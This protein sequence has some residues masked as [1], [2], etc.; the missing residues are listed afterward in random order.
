MIPFLQFNHRTVGQVASDI[1]LLL[2]DHVTI[3]LDYFPDVPCHI[4]EVQ[5]FMCMI[6]ANDPSFMSYL[7]L[8]IFPY[9]VQVIASTLAQLTPQEGIQMS[10]R[11]KRLLTSLLF[12]L[13]EWVMALPKEVLLSVRPSKSPSKEDQTSLLHKIFKVIQFF[14]FN[15][16]ALVFCLFI[17][18]CVLVQVL[19]KISGGLSGGGVNTIESYFKSDLLHEFDPSITLDNLKEGTSGGGVGG[20]R[21][22]AMPP[23]TYAH[24]QPCG[25]TVK[26][27]AKMV[28]NTIYCKQY[29]IIIIFFKKSLLY[30]VQI[31][32]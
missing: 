31:L 14:S 19:I 3:L 17:S 15:C 8:F 18:N 28:C 29:K 4:V 12:C 1:L 22:S 9:F 2:V 5:L 25:V 13:G 16:N 24:R 7:P 32:F 27:A 26:L 23:E 11:D 20:R 21:S 10:E 30:Q 6:M